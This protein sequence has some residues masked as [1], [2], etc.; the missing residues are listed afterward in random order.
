M[1]NQDHILV[2]D[3]SAS[4]LKVLERN[5]VS[6]GYVVNTAQNVANAIDFLENTAVDLVVTDLRMPKVGG[7]DLIRHIRSH[8]PD[9][10]VIMITGF[11]SISS[12]VSAM[13]QARL[14]VGITTVTSAGPEALLTG[15]SSSPKC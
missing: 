13:Q 2:V 1:A 9:T 12:A 3:D 14:Y 11:A 10:G 6:E 8:F 7:L 4:T 5:L 15:A